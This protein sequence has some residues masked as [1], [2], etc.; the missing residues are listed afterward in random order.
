PIAATGSISGET[1]EVGVES[2]SRVGTVRGRAID[3]AYR[4]RGRVCGRART[5]RAEQRD[6]SDARARHK[7]GQRAPCASTDRSNLPRAHCLASSRREPTPQRVGGG[8]PPAQ[9]G[10]GRRRTVGGQGV[11]NTTR[12]GAGPARVARED[13]GRGDGASGLWRSGTADDPSAA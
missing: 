5:A 4:V 2:E 13:Y 9:T 11:R 3:R 8:P 12:I 1:D 7:R 6:C 10:G